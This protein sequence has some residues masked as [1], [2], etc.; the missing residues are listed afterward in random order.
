[1]Q[2]ETSS[3]MEGPLSHTDGKVCCLGE[4]GGHDVSLMS[5]WGLLRSLKYKKFH[6]SVKTLSFAL[7]YWNR[8]LREALESVH[9]DTENSAG[10]SLW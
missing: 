8:L 5:S 10:C 4:V 6:L 7:K 2:K 1:M 3:L 9:G